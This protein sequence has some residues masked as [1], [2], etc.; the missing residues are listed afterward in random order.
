M[1]S[2]GECWH[3]NSKNRELMVCVNCMVEKEMVKMSGNHSSDHIVE[4]NP[5]IPVKCF[6]GTE[7]SA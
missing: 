7:L 6:H 5:L 2:I 4:P 1:V 3:R